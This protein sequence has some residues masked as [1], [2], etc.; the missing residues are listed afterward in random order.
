MKLSL[1]RAFTASTYTYLIAESRSSSS[2]NTWVI[3]KFPPL[4]FSPSSSILCIII[5][6]KESA[7]SWLVT[8][9]KQHCINSFDKKCSRGL[10]QQTITTF[11]RRAA[12]VEQRQSVSILNHEVMGLTPDKDSVSS[13]SHG[14]YTFQFDFIYCLG[15]LYCVKFWLP[16]AALS[17]TR[18][19][20]RLQVS[21]RDA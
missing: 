15:T 11:L 5:T 6:A 4:A 14:I 8:K 21:K 17:H 7:I 3:F 12:V 2:C 16:V 20:T 9:K 18:D 19:L 13:T 10:K 1:V